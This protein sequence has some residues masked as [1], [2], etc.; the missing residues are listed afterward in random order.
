MSVHH[1]GM[2]A[3]KFP[4]TPTE[5][6]ENVVASEH[7]ADEQHERQ[8]TQLPTQNGRGRRP[9]HQ[10]RAEVLA[11]AGELLLAQGVAGF[12]LEKVARQSGASRVTLNKY[13]PS[14]GALALEGYLHQTQ[15]RIEFVDTGVIHKDLI[16]VL[17][18]WVS[19]L[20]NPSQRLVFTQ[21][22]GAA[23][24]DRDLASAFHSHYF[25]PRRVEAI[26]LLTNAAARGQ[27]RNDV[28][29]PT[30]VDMIWGACYHRL[31]LP[32]LNDSLT[33]KYIEGL[34]HTVL[35]GVAPLPDQR[36]Q[37]EVS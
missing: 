13:W 29:F 19:H 28:D 34:V 16:T 17:G 18:A 5:S 8:S 12:T 22:I 37:T 21:L 20:S 26:Q 24:S 33:P 27:I 35:S 36:A 14:R 11:A 4:V 30:V 31:L 7:E 1:H 3:E 10:V 32:N 6:S 23:Q 2:S 15:G 25:G 9:E